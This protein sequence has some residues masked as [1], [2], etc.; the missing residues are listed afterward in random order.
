MS[1]RSRDWWKALGSADSEV[2]YRA[3]SE[4]AVI[5]AISLSPLLLAILGR[6]LK[7]WIDSGPEIPSFWEIFLVRVFCVQFFF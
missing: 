4:V 5:G 3:A 1:S 2:V 6:Y 7:G